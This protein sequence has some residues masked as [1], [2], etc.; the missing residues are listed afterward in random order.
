SGHDRRERHSGICGWN[1][2]EC[3]SHTGASNVTLAQRIT[4]DRNDDASE[5]AS[6]AKDRVYSATIGKGPGEAN[7]GSTGVACRTCWLKQ[8]ADVAARKGA[9]PGDESFTL[10]PPREFS[11]PASPRQIL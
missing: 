10:R 2:A 11:K 4:G 7:A 6:P 3:N 8:E 5:G 9:Q 1:Y